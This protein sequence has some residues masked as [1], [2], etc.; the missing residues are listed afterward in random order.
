[1]RDWT[2]KNGVANTS[3]DF[4]AIVSIVER[5]LRDH[6]LGDSPRQIAGLIIAQ[7][8]HKHGFAPRSDFSETDSQPRE[9]R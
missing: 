1:M 2:A 6:H 3:A 4:H 5:L 7:L 9:D 8:A